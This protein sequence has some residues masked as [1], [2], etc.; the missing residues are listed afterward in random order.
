MIEVRERCDAHRIGVVAL[1]DDGEARL[2]ELESE[3][4]VEHHIR[5]I[6]R[7]LDVRSRTELASKLSSTA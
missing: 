2:R 6:Y 4:T 3:R 5:N 7:K 1:D